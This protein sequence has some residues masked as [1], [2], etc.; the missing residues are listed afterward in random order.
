MLTFL[1]LMPVVSAIAVSMPVRNIFRIRLLC[2]VSII[3]AVIVVSFWRVLPPSEFCGYLALDYIGLILLSVISL[4]FVPVSIFMM[5][6]FK[7]EQRSGRR[8]VA[9]LLLLLSTMTLVSVSYHMGLLWVA[10]ETTTLFSAPLISFHKNRESLEATWK[11]LLV[12]SVGIAL[13]LIGTFFLAISAHDLRTLMLPEILCG[14]S[15]LSIDWLKLSVIFLFVGYG[16]KIGFAPMHSWKPEAYG[17]ATGMAAVIM[18]GGLTQCS[19]LALIRISQICFKTGLEDFYASILIVTGILSL[20]IPAVFIL[21]E[22]NLKRSFAY[23]SVEHMGI[24][25]LGLGLGGI[26]IF[27]AFFHMINNALAKVLM[28]LTAG[29]VAQKYGSSRMNDVRGVMHTYPVTGTFLIMALLGGTGIFPFATFHSEL[30]ILNA[31]ISSG[32]YI[33]SLAAIVCLAVMF[34]GLSRIVLGFAHGQPTE[35]VL[36]KKENFFM[37]TAIAISAIAL[38][39]LG[40]WMPVPIIRVISEAVRLVEGK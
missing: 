6:Y 11:Y 7:H 15:K 16:C 31:A 20:I 27:G 1:I 13:A 26:G 39:G 10:I 33:I 28:F 5:G 40:L 3:H 4:L 32:H 8:F 37:N 25:I 12:C 17:Q 35:P 29:S 38:I 19:F 30:M 22:K 14:A 2:A 23:S 36:A 34:I 9:C 21:G 18:A 24:L